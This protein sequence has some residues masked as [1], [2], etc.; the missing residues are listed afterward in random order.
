M[1]LTLR[2]SPQLALTRHP[3]RLNIRPPSGV[4]AQRLRGVGAPPSPLSAR[5]SVWKSGGHPASRV[6][7]RPGNQLHFFSAVPASVVATPRRLEWP[8]GSVGSVTL[9]WL[10]L[11]GRSASP[12]SLVCRGRLQV[13][14]PVRTPAPLAVEGRPSVWKSASLPLALPSPVT[15]PSPHSGAS[16]TAPR[17]VARQDSGDADSPNF[18]TTHGHGSPVLCFR[19]CFRVGHSAPVTPRRSAVQSP[20]VVGFG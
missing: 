4:T 2:T 8:H 11:S 13:T 15:L 10:G 1:P 6:A 9:P 18:T 14:L 12:S 16:V 7:L 20:P 5:L 17:S 19:H 3:P